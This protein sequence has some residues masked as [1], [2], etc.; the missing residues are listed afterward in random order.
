MA[1]GIR[2]NGEWIPKEILAYN[3]P[4]QMEI[5]AIIEKG[6]VLEAGTII[7]RRPT[8]QKY[9]A[10][11]HSEVSSATTPEAGAGN[12]GDGTCSAV[13]TD[14]DYTLTEDFV[15][16]ATGADEFTIEGS[17]SGILDP[18]TV[19]E[20]Y[21]GDKVTFTI[22][23]GETPFAEG[24]TFTFSTVAAGATVADGILAVDV[25]ATDDDETAP[26]Y[27]KGAFKISELIGF[28]DNAAT[29]LS[30]KISGNVFIV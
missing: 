20:E 24:D 6:Q 19:G 17:V 15:L 3:V 10:Y 8:S 13:V 25:D 11:D 9:I 5:P 23:A 26:R 12:T 4:E 1:C 22:T 21:V 7:G 16:E 30:G 2:D 14:D 27:M 29:N 18:V 28:D